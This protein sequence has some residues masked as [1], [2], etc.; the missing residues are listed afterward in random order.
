MSGVSA[1]CPLTALIDGQY[2]KQNKTLTK[3]AFMLGRFPLALLKALLQGHQPLPGLAE[4]SVD[5]TT[6]DVTALRGR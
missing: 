1:C 3:T 5:V 2:V 4:L 6:D